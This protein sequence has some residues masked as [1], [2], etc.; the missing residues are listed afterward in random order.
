MHP[1]PSTIGQLT[2]E[3]HTPITPEMIEAIDSEDITL[4]KT[5]AESLH[6]ETKPLLGL[7]SIPDLV[8]AKRNREAMQTKI[9]EA[10]KGITDKINDLRSFSKDLEILADRLN[11]DYWRLHEWQKQVESPR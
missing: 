4:I 7:M 2:E 10:R 11:A 9:K 3:H 5:R 6:S 8:E 1:E